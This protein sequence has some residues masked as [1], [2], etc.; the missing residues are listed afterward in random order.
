[1]ILQTVITA[2]G[3]SR[4]KFL[5]AGFHVPKSLVQIDGKLVI[6]RAI[7]SYAVDINNLH[8]AVNADEAMEWGVDSTVTRLF[9]SARVVQVSSYARG[10]LASALMCTEMLKL[11][12]PLVVAA[13][14]SSI[15]GG[16]ERFVKTFYDRKIDA[17]TVV[18]EST[19][20]RW[21]YVSTDEDGRVLEVS[22]K[23]QVGN[24]ATTGVFYFRKAKSFM[25]GAE[26]VLSNN[27]NLEGNY[28]VSTV[29]N[30]LISM[31]RPVGFETIEAA[32][33]KSWSKPDDF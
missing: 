15:T 29:M 22:E 2:A 21:S 31:D 16:I 18:F 25:Q 10:A 8:V 6:E 1:M 24:L 4:A 5:D 26:W 19:G 12:E 30:Y 9:P 20:P 11:D 23:F 7:E 28:Y 17:G 33:Y 3:D 32:D 13:G 27:A 14:D